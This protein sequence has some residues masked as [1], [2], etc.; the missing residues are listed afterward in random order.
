MFFNFVAIFAYFN[1][2]CSD[3]FFLRFCREWQKCRKTLQQ[4]FSTFLDLNVIVIMIILD[5]L[6]YLVDFRLNFRFHFQSNFPRAAPPVGVGGA[7]G[8]RAAMRDCCE[9]GRPL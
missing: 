1:E 2:I 6:S 9:S 7:E 5:S 8:R 4:Y 3:Y